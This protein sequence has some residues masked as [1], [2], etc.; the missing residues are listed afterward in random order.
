MRKLPIGL[1]KENP[2]SRALKPIVVVLLVLAS[3]GDAF[4]DFP[5]YM[6]PGTGMCC[7]ERAT[8]ARPVTTGKTSTGSLASSVELAGRT[9]VLLMPQWHASTAAASSVQP[10]RSRGF[11]ARHPVLVG[12]IFGAVAGGSVAF[13]KWGSEGTWVGVWL[14][15]G[16]GG[17]IGALLSR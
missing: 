9:T 7:R 15:A 17:G 8:F 1:Q 11:V 2:L 12:A 3:Y 13:A 5:D 10:G 6:S 4:A 14:G 16:T